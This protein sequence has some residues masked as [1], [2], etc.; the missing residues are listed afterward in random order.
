MGGREVSRQGSDPLGACTTEELLDIVLEVR[1]GESTE[2]CERAPIAA[3]DR[4]DDLR[5]VG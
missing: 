5:L 2:R 1:T 4:L 3:A